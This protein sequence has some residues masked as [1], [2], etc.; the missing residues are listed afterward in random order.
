MQGP[1]EVSK[2]LENI[3]YPLQATW[4]HH[5]YH[6]ENLTAGYRR[7]ISEAVSPSTKVRSQR[8]INPRAPEVV[9]PTTEAR[10]VAHTN[11]VP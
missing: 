8:G 9:G 10:C 4:E 7:F 5:L 6:Q 3:V 1:R 11:E 2:W